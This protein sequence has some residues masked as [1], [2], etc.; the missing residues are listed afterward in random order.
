MNLTDRM[1]A[2]ARAQHRAW[3]RHQRDTAP[4]HATRSTEPDDA[5]A[6]DA[7]LLPHPTLTTRKDTPQ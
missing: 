7:L 3:L 6:P 5:S 2:T 1:F 4:D